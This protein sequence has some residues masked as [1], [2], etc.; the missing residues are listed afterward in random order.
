MIDF[1]HRHRTTEVRHPG[2]IW[3]MGDVGIPQ[4]ANMPFCRFVTWFATWTANTYAPGGVPIAYNGALS[5]H[6]PAPRHNNYKS[7]VLLVDGHVDT[8]SYDDF[9]LNKEDIWGT[10]NGL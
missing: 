3:L 1:L 5:P 10:I 7:N 9:R 4:A 2:A 6:Q 8:R